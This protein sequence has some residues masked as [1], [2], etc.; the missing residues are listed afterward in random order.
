ME[1]SRGERVA[2][3]VSLVLILG[4]LVIDLDVLLGGRLLGAAY[5]PGDDGQEAGTDDSG[6]TGGD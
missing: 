5:G 6:S 2:A 3:L 1:V 4:L